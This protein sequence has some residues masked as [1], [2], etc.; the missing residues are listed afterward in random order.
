M[1]QGL[2]IGVI[3]GAPH[4]EEDKGEWGGVRGRDTQK[5]GEGGMN[6]VILGIGVLL[7]APYLDDEKGEG[8]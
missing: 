2:G 4:L 5:E 6:E 8:E 7:V 1:V 3:L